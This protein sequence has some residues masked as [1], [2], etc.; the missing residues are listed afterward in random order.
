MNNYFGLGLDAD[1]CLDFHMAREE[2][3]NKFNS[4]SVETNVRKKLHL[5]LSFSESKRKDITWRRAFGRW[6]RRA[7]WRTF[8]AILSSK[9]TENVS[10]FRHWKALWS[11]I[12]SG[13]FDAE[14]R[15]SIARRCFRFQLGEWRQSLGTRKRWE[16]LSSNAL[17]W[18]VGSCRSDRNCT[19]RSNTIGYSFRC[20]IGSRWTCKMTTLSARSPPSP[21]LSLQIHIR[22]N[23]DCPIPVQVDGEPW[24]QP[25]C[26]ITII[27]S[28]LKV[29]GSQK[30]MFRFDRISVFRQQCFGNANRKSNVEILNRMF[31]FPKQMMIRNL[32]QNGKH[33]S[34]QL[35]WDSS[36]AFCSSPKQF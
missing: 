23:N 16:I 35:V 30:K 13:L 2:N 31:V 24:L 29:N 19:F 14:R 28:A 1:I 8:L 12:F 21:S 34:S 32:E 11:S 25:P 26:E 9:W 17:R 5:G 10:N 33:V 27:R 18:H 20:S 36:A 15:R 6:W 4:R 3:P 22:M 7:V